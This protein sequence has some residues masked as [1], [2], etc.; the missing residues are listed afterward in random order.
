MGQRHARPLR[1]FVTPSLEER[2]AA[3]AALL[4]GGGME[5]EPVIEEFLRHLVDEGAVVA[6]DHERIIEECLRRLQGAGGAGLR[7]GPSKKGAGK[8]VYF[9]IAV[10]DD[11]LEEYSCD[12]AGV[13]EPEVTGEPP[14]DRSVC[15][16][17]FEVEGTR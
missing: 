5:N 11:E 10:D 1:C 16:R 9:D 2:A 4:G 6:A 8:V 12:W 14:E 15:R 3:K 17:L 13:E 7:R